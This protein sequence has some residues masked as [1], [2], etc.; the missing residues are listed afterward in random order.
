MKQKAILKK[1]I[2]PQ[3]LKDSKLHKERTILK[4]DISPQR[5]KDSKLH[6]KDSDLSE[7]KE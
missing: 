2:S 6:I 1:V 3:R 4:K 7:K 5:L